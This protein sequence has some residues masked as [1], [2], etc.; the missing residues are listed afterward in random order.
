MMLL[1]PVF[2]NKLYHMLNNPKWGT[3]VTVVD[4]QGDLTGINAVL[5]VYE[6]TKA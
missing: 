3:V 4:I 6:A 5:L 2:G 1:V